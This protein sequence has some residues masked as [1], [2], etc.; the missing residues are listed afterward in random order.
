VI[1]LSFFNEGAEFMTLQACTYRIITDYEKGP[2][3]ATLLIAL[4][5]LP[6]AFS[7]V[8]GFLSDTLDIAGFRKR[9]YICVAALIQIVGSFLL[10]REGPEKG[11]LKSEALTSLTILART[12]AQPVVDSL[13]IVQMKR[14]VLRG[15]EDLETFT[16]IC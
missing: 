1:G 7:F 16:R 14:D 15:S 8:F 4:V 6:V 10:L 9:L 2:A 13:L 12:I 3:E 5:T 11:L